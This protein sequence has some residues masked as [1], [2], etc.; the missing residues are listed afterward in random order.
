MEVKSL[1]E[2]E[3][4]VMEIIWRDKKASVPDV[5]QQLRQERK[6][7][8]TTVATIFQRLC[9]KGLLKREKPDKSH[10]YIF[11]PK[12]GKKTYS[13]NLIRSF[14]NR[15]INSFGETAIVSFAQGIEALPQ[16]RRKKL[17]DLLKEY[18]RDQQKP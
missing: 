13:R 17:L 4:E 6:I 18:E 10:C 9:D 8:Y 5:Y 15:I 2:L 12:M 1:G 3:R 7:A 16:R 11:S 14:I